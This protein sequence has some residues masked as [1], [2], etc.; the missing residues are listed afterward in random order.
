[1]GIGTP[2]LRVRKMSD[3]ITPTKSTRY[4]QIRVGGEKVYLHRFVYEQLYGPI[5]SG[6]CVCHKCDNKRCVNPE[7]LFLGTYQDNMLDMVAKN[8]HGRVSLRG[9]ARS[10]K[11]TE[12][13][14]REIRAASVGEDAA[15]AKKFGMAKCSI[16]MIRN[17][18][19]WAHLP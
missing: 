12:E 16:N 9:E 13:N 19:K 3:C 5:P 6:L 11:L 8:R 17:R 1:M 7:H 15:L 18:K 14:V 4:P 10:K 2:A